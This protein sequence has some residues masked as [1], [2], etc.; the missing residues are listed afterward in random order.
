MFT[1]SFLGLPKLKLAKASG[2]GAPEELDEEE[3]LGEKLPSLIVWT[4]G[5]ALGLT[6]SS[7]ATSKTFL[8]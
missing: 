7:I 2:V 3:E 8:L 5:I 4:E 6:H 1:L